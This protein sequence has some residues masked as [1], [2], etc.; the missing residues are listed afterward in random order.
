MKN[1]DKKLEEVESL[2][3][4]NAAEIFQCAQD[5]EDTEGLDSTAIEKMKVLVS[6]AEKL[7]LRHNEL[8]ESEER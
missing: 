3:K 5:I 8:V 1:V 6:R 4:K 2:A 7:N